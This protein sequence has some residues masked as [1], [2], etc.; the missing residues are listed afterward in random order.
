MIITA[1][2]PTRCGRIPTGDFGRH[3]SITVRDAEQAYVGPLKTWEEEDAVKV[4]I[5][6]A[7]NMGRGIGASSASGAR[8]SCTCR[9]R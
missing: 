1:H 7:S 6:G 5:I 2:R 4:T 8:S 3:E 9:G